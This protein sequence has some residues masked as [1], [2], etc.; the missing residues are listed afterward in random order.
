MDRASHI[1]AA[2]IDPTSTP[3]LNIEFKMRPISGI[4]NHV[5]RN[6]SAHFNALDVVKD[7][8]MVDRISHLKHSL[9]RLDLS[10][11]N[12]RTYPTQLCTLYLLESL[13]LSCNHLSELDFPPECDRLQ[14]LVE[15]TIDSNALKHIPK[16]LARCKKLARLSLRN[17]ALVDLRHLDTLKRL[18]ILALDGNVLTHLDDSIRNLDKLEYFHASNNEI[19][20]IQFNLFKTSLNSLRQLDLSF[21]KLTF[22]STELFTLPHLELLNLSNNSLTKLPVIQASHLR[23]I[24]IYSIDLSVNLLTRFYDYVLVL[25]QNVDFSANRLKTLPKKSILKMN[26]TELEM[27]QLKLDGNPLV[28]P[29]LEVNILKLVDLFF[30]MRFICWFH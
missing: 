13:N 9:K 1:N 25:A 2:E 3:T 19:H 29:P 30:F 10:H 27:K 4:R 15:L 22:I 21:N 17:N 8:D 11:N 14:S 12:L 5:K 23:T 24:P 18:R 20:T 6:Q 7:T 16:P 28:D 26:K